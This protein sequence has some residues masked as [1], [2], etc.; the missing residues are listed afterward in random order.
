MLSISPQDVLNGLCSQVPPAQLA[1]QGPSQAV[2]QQ[3]FVVA[4][5]AVGAQWP[6]PH[7]VSAEHESLSARALQTLSTQEGFAEGHSLSAQH[8]A[9]AVR[10]QAVEPGHV[11]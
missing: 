1:L 11:R 5:D 10:M 8:A 7:S 2:L 3:T 4:P 6:L 9:G